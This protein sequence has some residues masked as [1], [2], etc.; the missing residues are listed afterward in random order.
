M[1]QKKRAQGSKSARQLTYL[2][3]ETLER[4]TMLAAAAGSVAFPSLPTLYPLADLI[5]ARGAARVAGPL[6]DNLYDA[7]GG[8]GSSL[9]GGIAS[10]PAKKLAPFSLNFDVLKQTLATAP[11]EFTPAAESKPLVL[12]LPMPD[13]T[14]SRFQIV[15]APVM[16][17]LLAAQFPEIRTFRGVGIDDPTASVRLDYSPRGFRAQ[18]LSVNGS[19]YIDPYYQNDGGGTYASYF[20]RD[21]VKTA[22]W[23]C[24]ITE[25]L[26][27]AQEAAIDAMTAPS[28]AVGAS[29]PNITYA[30]TLR[31]FRAAVAANGEYTTA[32]SSPSAPSVALG[33]AAVVTAMNRVSGVYETELGIRMTLIANNSSIIYTNAGTDPYVNGTNDIDNNITNL[34]NTIGNANFDIGH[35]FTTGSGGVAY[36]GVVGTSSKAGGTTGLPSPTGDAFYIDYV[37][38]EMGHQFGG[39]HTFN[40]SNDSSNRS[41]LHAY[42][43]G[44]GST[45]MAYAGIEGAED[46]QPNS[47]PYFHSESI[48]EIRAYIGTIPSVG[49]STSTG[50]IA[51]VISALTNYTIPTGTPF[52]LTASATDANGDA[53]TYDWQERDKGAATLLTTADNGASPLFRAWA[54]TTSGTRTLPKLARILDGTNQTLN[55]SSRPVEKLFAVPRTS[56]WRVIAR[57]NKVGGGGVTTADMT[58]TVVNTGAAFAVTAPNV[59]GITWAGGS[60]QTVTWN[61]SGTTANGINTANVNILLSTDGGNTFP[62]NL[63]VGGTANDGTQTVQM[64]FN[65]GSTTARIKVEAIGNV[66]FDIG[67]ANFTIT[68]VAGPTA[69]PGLPV[70]VSETGTSNS[71]GIVNLNNTAGK[72]LTFSVPSTVSGAA[73]TLFSGATVIGTGTGNGGSLNIVTNGTATIADGAASITAKQQA[74]GQTLSAASPALGITVDTVRPTSTTVFRS[75]ATQDITVVFSEDLQPSITNSGAATLNLQTLGGS[76]VASASMAV[77]YTAGTKTAVYTFPGLANQ[78]LADGAYNATPVATDVAG[79]TPSSGAL[80]FIYGGGTTAHTFYLRTNSGA[81]TIEVYKNTAP[82]G[83]PDITAPFGSPSQIVFD[84]SSV[85]DSVTIDY[86]LG[87]PLPAGASGFAFNGGNGSDT[88][89]LTGNNTFTFYADASPAT[90]NLSVNSTGTDITFNTSQHL[91]ALSL[92]A[93]AD[94]TLIAGPAKVLVTGALAIAGSTLKLFE[95]DM[96]V[97]SGVVA[98]IDGQVATG[99]IFSGS[100]LTGTTL[101]VAPAGDALNIS[102]AQTAPFVGETVSPTNI[103][104]KF[105]Y[106]GDANLDGSINADDYAVIDLYSQTPGSNGYWHGDFNRSGSINADD[107]AWIDLNTMNPGAPL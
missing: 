48:Q 92:N 102:G 25:D 100:A 86:S 61:V 84:G 21:L 62:I 23:D 10:V 93:G 99:E 16:D 54:P 8:L 50:N 96:I 71:D 72:Q 87:N 78:K 34:S 51:P 24:Q 2:Q 43:P 33:Q 3:G 57:D 105:T 6:A 44:S 81:S 60:N 9:N 19:Y 103:L 38:H 94:A 5:G 31:T 13:G 67:N 66:F 4:R 74:T 63:T 15:E 53:I 55:A 26:P 82:D 90:S 1:K 46:L 106:T 20:K 70:L 97:R 104:V 59:A 37:A 80:V 79:N 49:T 107:Y 64:P 69:A 11:L 83:S 77:N 56:T 30:G 75:G 28:L 42:E 40:T 36:L 12:P 35:V 18:V 7:I 73:V 17:P 95:N 85:N 47:D 101:A 68:N 52:A 58:L 39:N 14:F 65:T 91:A 98:T 89:N 27:A 29:A 22:D 41:A 88:L 32:V 76:P 45:I